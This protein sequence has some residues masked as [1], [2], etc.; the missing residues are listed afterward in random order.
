MAKIEEYTKQELK[1][2][3]KAAVVLLDYYKSPSDGSPVYNTCPLCYDHH[4]EDK[5]KECIWNLDKADVAVQCW[6]EGNVD[7]LRRWAITPFPGWLG[8]DW[9]DKRIKEISV[10]I[11]KINEQLECLEQVDDSVWHGL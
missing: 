8:W 5:C 4:L 2:M 9:K 10:A 6:S 1:G 11:K 7:K 3:V